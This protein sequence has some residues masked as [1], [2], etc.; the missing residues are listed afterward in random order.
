[1]QGESSELEIIP[2]REYIN[3]GKNQLLVSYFRRHA[4]FAVTKI[5]IST[6]I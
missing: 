4:T 1:M 5:N 6:Y 2:F 3:F